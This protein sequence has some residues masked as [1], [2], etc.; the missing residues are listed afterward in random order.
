MSIQGKVWSVCVIEDVTDDIS[1]YCL[2]VFTDETYADDVKRRLVDSIERV[3]DQI[4]DNGDEFFTTEY[5]DDEELSNVISNANLNEGIRV[6][7]CDYKIF[8]NQ[9][10]LYK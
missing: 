10:V 1:F 3:I 8:V 7:S 2:G 5:C 9:D 6:I 4:D